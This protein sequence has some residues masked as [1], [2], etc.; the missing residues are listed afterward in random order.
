MSRTQLIALKFVVFVALG[1]I[2]P[3]LVPPPPPPDALALFSPSSHTCF[4]QEVGVWGSRCLYSNGSARWAIDDGIQNQLI[5]GFRETLWCGGT[6][7]QRAAAS[8]P[9]W[10][11][12]IIKYYHPEARDTG[13]RLRPIGPSGWST[14][15]RTR[16]HT[17]THTHTHTVDSK[18][19]RLCYFPGWPRH[20]CPLMR[21][22]SRGCRRGE[23]CL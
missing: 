20:M 16:A 4:G 21:L 1:C 10:S 14:N 17:H 9:E 23:F 7:K 13:Q 18:N 12:T 5:P 15:T 2:F 22:G 3:A 8:D 6:W 11:L 19:H